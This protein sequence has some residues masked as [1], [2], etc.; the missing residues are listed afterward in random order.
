MFFRKP[1]LLP[2]DKR[3]RFLLE[4]L[5]RRFNRTYAE[6]MVRYLNIF[7]PLFRKAQKKDEF[8][9]IF[10]LLRFRGIQP[11]DN[12]PY[13]NSIKTIDAIMKLDKKMKGH[14]RMNVFLW[15]YG[16]II[17]SSEPYELIAN[18][19]NILDGGGYVAWNFPKKQRGNDYFN[20]SPSEKIRF[21]EH[22]ALI[23]GVPQLVDPIKEILDKDIRNAVFHS[24]F[25]VAYDASV[26]LNDPPKIYKHEEI[27][28]I[29]NKALA[30]HEVMKNIINAYEEGYDKSRKIKVSPSFSNDPLERGTII[31]R[32]GKGL[33][34]IKSSWNKKQLSGGKIPWLMANMLGYERK[35]LDKGITELPR[36]RVA[37]ANN[38][39]LLFPRIIRRRLSDPFS[40]LVNK[41]G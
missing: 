2:R 34:G 5:P 37:I 4:G 24:D 12:D 10:T 23:L 19:L 30:Y 3:G 7:D 17:E 39:L 21:L 9:F 41:Y 31:V 15:V 8:Q 20:Q 16:H 33:V 28:Q 22:K 6:A 18:L 35:Y 13:E 36:D 1:P 14:E 26:I 27:M 32:K 40:S 11:T 29:L 38:I 25:A